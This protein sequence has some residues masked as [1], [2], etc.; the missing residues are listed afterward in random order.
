MNKTF[1]KEIPTARIR[2][3]KTIYRDQRLLGFIRQFNFE[4]GIRLFCDWVKTQGPVQSD[5]EGSIAEMKK[6]G[7]LK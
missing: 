2:R 7:L 1:R 6:K 5:Y 4:A 3:L